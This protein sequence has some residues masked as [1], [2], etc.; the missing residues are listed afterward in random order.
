MAIVCNFALIIL[1]FF[2]IFLLSYTITN[3][4]KGFSH[5]IALLD[6][7]IVCLQKLIVNFSIEMFSHHFY[8]LA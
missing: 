6:M 8:L 1:N 2:V 4:E 7:K 5:L 3:S